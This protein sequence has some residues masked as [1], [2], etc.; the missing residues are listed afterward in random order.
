MKPLVASVAVFAVCLMASPLSRAVTRPPSGNSH[1]TAAQVQRMIRK[2]HTPDEY[3]AIA[4][5]YD[6]LQREFSDKAADQMAEWAR[7]SQETTGP[8][9]KY[10]RPIDAARNLYEFYAH[11]A[12]DAAFQADK[13]YRF[14]AG[15]AAADK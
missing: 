8:A 9:A 12:D 3:R 5:Y 7:R 1:H 6:E 13:Y 4:R 2:A 14:A 15:A 11:H 10:P